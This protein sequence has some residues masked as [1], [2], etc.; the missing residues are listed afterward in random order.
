[1]A[2]SRAG[3]AR[4]TIAM[5]II[6]RDREASSF[7]TPLQISTGLGQGING[8]GQASKVWNA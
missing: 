1:M 5:R 8:L 4:E 3:K 6:D 7:I 2:I